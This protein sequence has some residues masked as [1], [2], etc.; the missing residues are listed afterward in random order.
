MKKYFAELDDFGADMS[1]T[2]D[3][4]TEWLNSPPLPT[5]MDAIAWWA[6]MSEAGDP[7]APMALDFL[8]APGW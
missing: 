1:T 4:I 6:A 2:G 3:V 5:V 8:S 7:L